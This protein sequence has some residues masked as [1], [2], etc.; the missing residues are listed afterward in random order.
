[1]KIIKTSN[2]SLKAA[3]DSSATGE[4]WGLSILANLDNKNKKPGALLQTAAQAQSMV[5]CPA[6]SA[7]FQKSARADFRLC[8][9]LIY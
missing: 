6:L 7:S 1:L 2:R 4:A 9:R 5:C 3:G 8:K